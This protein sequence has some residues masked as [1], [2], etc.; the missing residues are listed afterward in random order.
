MGSVDLL[1]N[2]NCD[3]DLGSTSDPVS[4]VHMPARA[5]VSHSHDHTHGETVL[6]SHHSNLIAGR[7]R[8]LVGPEDLHVLLVDDDD[9]ALASMQHALE[10]CHYT[11]TSCLNGRKAMSIL[12][13]QPTKYDVVLTDALMP[14]MNGLS[15]LGAIQENIHLRHIP[16]ILVSSS[17]SQ[18]MQALK[19]GAKDYLVKPL[20]VF[21]AMTLFPKVK[22]WNAQRDDLIGQKTYGEK[23][24]QQS[25]PR[26]PG[27]INLA[28][29]EGNISLENATREGY[30]KGCSIDA[31]D[32][33]D[34]TG[35]IRIGNGGKL[36]HMP[37]LFIDTLTQ[38]MADRDIRRI[39][40]KDVELIRLAGIGSGG[41]V[42]KAKLMIDMLLGLDIAKAKGESMGNPKFSP[43]CIVACK[44]FSRDMVLTQTFGEILTRDKHV[45]NTKT[46]KHYAILRLV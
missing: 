3:T 25:K 29:E 27:H 19:L 24:Q 21:E 18:I 12:Q 9:F 22:I 8:T 42:Y 1:E 37:S 40:W 11:V 31:L 41:S 39:S 43:K 36:K 10:M 5:P 30:V 17:T 14:A 28:V 38:N 23:Q 26:E 15:L 33:V 6:V 44:R 46:S 7:R 16:I 2:N 45:G 34:M 35:H 4:R 32:N 20:R 13:S